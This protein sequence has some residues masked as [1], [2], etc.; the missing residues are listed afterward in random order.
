[1]AS[2][3]NGHGA[4]PAPLNLSPEMRAQVTHSIDHAI[5]LVIARLT[6]L[7]F[8]DDD[9]ALVSIATRAAILEIVKRRAQKA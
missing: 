4:A 5:G 7:G 6:G 3:L 1:M 8:D 9:K 2:G